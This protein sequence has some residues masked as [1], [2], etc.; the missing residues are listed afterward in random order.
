MNR[1]VTPL[2]GRVSGGGGQPSLGTD[3]GPERRGG[4]SGMSGAT[5][6]HDSAERDDSSLLESRD[7]QLQVWRMTLRARYVAIMAVA[8][9]ALLPVAEPHGRWISLALVVVVMPYNYLYDWLMR[10]TNRLS[11]IIAFSD[12]VHRGGVRRLRPGADRSDPARHAGHQRHLG[13]RV[14][15]Q[16]RGRRRRRRMHRRRRRAVGPATRATAGP[17]SSS[18]RWRPRSSSRWWAASPASSARCGAATS[19]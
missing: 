5:A 2:R 14:R 13:R 17:R 6:E 16:G 8:A 19:I 10:R 11:P 3:P 18:T 1:H 9:A 4:R 12:Q 15:T 7:R